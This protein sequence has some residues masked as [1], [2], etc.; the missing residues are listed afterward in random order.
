MDTSVWLWIALIGLLV[1]CCVPM[2]FMGRRGRKPAAKEE[3]RKPG[4]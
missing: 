4:L 2:L 1:L 3:D